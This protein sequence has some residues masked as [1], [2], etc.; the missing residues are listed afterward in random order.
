M[1]SNLKS[2]VEYVNIGIVNKN[3]GTISN[4]NGEFVLAIPAEFE[5]DSVR[6]SMVGYVPLTLSVADL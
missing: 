4:N 1:N 6:F 5:N 2:P 3:I